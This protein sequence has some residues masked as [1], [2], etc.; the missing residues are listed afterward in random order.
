MRRSSRIVPA[1]AACAAV[2]CAA[3]AFAAAGA[4]VGKKDLISL[5]LKDADI[6]QVVKILGDVT[7]TVIIPHRDLEGKVSVVGLENVEPD[8]VVGVLK[9]AL[10]VRGFTL[11]KSGK[12][13]KVVPLAETRQT[14][15]P[16]KVGTEPEKISDEDVVITQ[17]MPLKF[18]SAVSVKNDLQSLVGRH[19]NILAHERTNTL[20]ITDTS[21]NIKRLATIIGEMDKRLPPK[22]QVKTF[23]LNYGDAKKVAE[24]LTSLSNKDQKDAQ[25]PKELKK[26][27]GEDPLELY[28]EIRA[29]VEAETNSIVVTTAPVNFPSIEKLVKKLDI[30]PPQAMIEVI[31]MDV[32]LDDDLAMGI[33]FSHATNPTSTSDGYKTQLDHDNR[34]GVF[35]SLLGFVTDAA[36]EGFTYRV[37]DP[38]ERINVLGFILQTIENSKV[39][40]T[41]KILASNNQE[42]KITVGQEV[43]IIESSVTDLVNNVTTVNY[44]YQDV[45][46]TLNVTPRISRDGFV[47]MKVHAEL[48]DL[49]PQ[50]IYNASIINKREADAT[51]L[52]PDNYTVVLGGLMRDNDSVIES[53]IPLLGSIPILGH[54]FKRTKKVSLK[55]E[56]IVFLTPHVLK[57]AK[58][59]EKITKP[60]TDK[61]TTAREMGSRMKLK[62]TVKKI[63]APAGITRRERREGR[64]RER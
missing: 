29:F 23:V 36:T 63:V 62:K 41:P 32:T 7:G 59:L 50:T 2:L 43:P 8:V 48:K 18:S 47:N 44:K 15:V 21:S 6:H 11:V 30:F 5:N 40:S 60:S 37:L 38:K 57:D 19:G 17:V 49:S 4:P 54:I 58:D 56:L 31:I 24:I 42:S 13:L 12:A 45:G 10:M 20:V 25:Y 22:A 33:E 1:A 39:L 27:A 52:I 35:H 55:T 64:Q 61:L 26:I 9:S 3:V 28:G 16:V 14:N 46:M 34:E 51:V 53:K